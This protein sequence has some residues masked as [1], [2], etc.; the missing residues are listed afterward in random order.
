[1]IIHQ[2]GIDMIAAVANGAAAEWSD[3]AS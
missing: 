2:L 3:Y 1:M